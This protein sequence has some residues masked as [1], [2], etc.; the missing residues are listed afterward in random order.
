MTRELQQNTW[1]TSDPLF[2]SYVK[3][4][5]PVTF[6][7]IAHWLKDLLQLEGVDGSIYLAHSVRGACTSAALAKGVHLADI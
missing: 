3:S 6:Q 2:L 4:H 1:D 5:K 7:R